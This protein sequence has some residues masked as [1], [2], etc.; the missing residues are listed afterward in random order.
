[1]APPMKLK[2]V[3]EKMYKKANSPFS[4]KTIAFMARDMAEE[5]M[6]QV[7]DMVM[8]RPIRFKNHELVSKN[9][10]G[11]LAVTDEEILFIF[12]N[13]VL[14]PLNVSETDIGE[15]I[16]YDLV[17]GGGLEKEFSD[18]KSA[19]VTDFNSKWRDED[20]DND[21]GFSLVVEGSEK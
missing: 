6:S 16:T 1:M 17:D 9:L 21:G 12:R 19:L 20:S 8:K 4:S 11:E 2:R 7:Q 3:I 18:F 5:V 13:D 15:T 14:A 10:G